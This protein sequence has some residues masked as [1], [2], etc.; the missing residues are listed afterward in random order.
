MRVKLDWLNTG[1]EHNFAAQT[2]AVFHACVAQLFLCVLVSIA[3][4]QSNWWVSGAHSEPSRSILGVRKAGLAACAVIF[5]QLVLGAVMRHSHAGLA[6]P[7]FPLT[8]A[9]GLL[10]DNWSFPVAIHFAHR[11]WAVVV[12]VAVGWFVT[13]LWAGRSIERVFG[14]GAVALGLLILLQIY[15]GALIIWTGRNPHAATIHMLTGAFLLASCWG[16]TFLSYRQV[17]EIPARAPQ[18][19]AISSADRLKRPAGA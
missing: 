3:V 16:L 15:L 2:F 1:A 10:P 14:P 19:G 4:A 8:P 7:T 5:V 13:R 12:L 17:I 6:I 11:S 18:S 9:G